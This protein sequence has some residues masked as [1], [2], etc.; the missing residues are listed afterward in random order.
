MADYDYD[1]EDEEED[2]APSAPFWMTTFSDM[3]TLLLTFF[4]LI[5]SMS[6][7][8][9]KKFHEA[10]SYFQGRT[11]VLTNEAIV[12][13]ATRRVITD[14]RSREQSQRYE[15]LLQYLREQ[16][17]E[18]K[19]QVNLTDK[20]LHVT[21]TD[22][23]MFASGSAMLVGVSKE[24]LRRIRAV[25]GSD[26]ES[27]VVEGHTDDRPIQTLQFPSNWELSAARASS[28]VRFLLEE[29]NELSPARYLAVGYGEFHP[30][31][32]NQTAAGRSRNRRVEILFSWEP[33]QNDRTPYLPRQM[34]TLR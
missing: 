19:V 22:S 15:E 24:L 5:V 18:D 31:D 3:V 6:S 25:L 33:W 27:V 17:L 28:V 14:F 8:E 2:G 10:L 9:I 26:V 13:S 7:V 11:S 12:Q 23:V 4:V 21:I 29:E 32:T 20:G 1:I 30:V 16:G 34:T